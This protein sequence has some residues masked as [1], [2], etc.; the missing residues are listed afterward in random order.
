MGDFADYYRGIEWEP[1]EPP[2]PPPP[3]GKKRFFI[4]WNPG[5]DLPPRVAMATRKQAERTAKNMR[6]MHGGTFF[7]MEFKPKRKAKARR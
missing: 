3:T 4:L 2:R 7:V 5:S 1:P 6:E